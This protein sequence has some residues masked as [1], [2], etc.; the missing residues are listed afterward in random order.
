MKFNG[1]YLSIPPYISTSWKNIKALQMSGKS[2]L[3]T[4]SDDNIVSVPDLD[5]E[6]I[7]QIFQTH[8]DFLEMGDFFEKGNLNTPFDPFKQNPPSGMMP[9]Q[10]MEFPFK[11][12]MN[13][14]MDGL[15]AALQHN[16]EHANAPDMPLEILSK[17]ASIAKIVAPEGGGVDVPKPEPHCNCPHCQIARAINEGLG[18]PVKPFAGRVTENH[19]DNIEEV[20]DDELS[21]QQ[22][23]IDQA[24]DKLYV[25]SNKLDQDEKYNVYL[26]EPVGCTC[27][28]CGCEHILAV[29]HS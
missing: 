22:W 20:S 18:N 17:V 14:G 5:L 25:V 15:G 26:G 11:I 3:I 23:R 12:G 13:G 28:Q 6:E 7:E 29:L 24:G 10:Q 4:L 21:F 19:H 8:A 1:K 16:W 2:L 27:G 9:N